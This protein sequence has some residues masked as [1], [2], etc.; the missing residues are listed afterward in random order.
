MSLFSPMI[1][2]VNMPKN[3]LL[4]N[5]AFKCTL[6]SVRHT[7][8]FHEQY[9]INVG[10]LNPFRKRISYAYNSDFTQSTRGYS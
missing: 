7:R 6:T 9:L 1:S 2:A 3:C 4:D 10:I 5:N 8:R